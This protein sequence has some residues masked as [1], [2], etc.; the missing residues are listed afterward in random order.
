MNS[1]NDGFWKNI[2][3]GSSQKINRSR[4]QIRSRTHRSARVLRRARICSDQIAPSVLAV[5][6]TDQ[7]RCEL[8]KSTVVEQIIREL[9][10]VEKL[11]KLNSKGTP[12][13]DQLRTSK[14]E[15]LRADVMRGVLRV[16]AACRLLDLVIAEC[17]A[18]YPQLIL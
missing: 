13:L 14:L 16:L 8:K 9:Q 17:E 1:D 3:I 6:N 5:L 12:K 7:N 11:F 4:A 18:L 10:A 15:Q 2:G